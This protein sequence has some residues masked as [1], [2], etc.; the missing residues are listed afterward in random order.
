MSTLSVVIPAWNEESGIQEIMDRVLSVR[1][2]LKTVGID[3]LE[4]IVVD[5]GSTDRRQRSFEMPPCASFNTPNAAMALRSKQALPQRKANGLAFWMQT[6]PIRRNT[7][8]SC[9]RRT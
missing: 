5:D 6:V 3:D 1:E 4:L 2:P 7:F 9:E 8:P